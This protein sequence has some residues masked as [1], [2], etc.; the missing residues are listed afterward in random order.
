MTGDL[1]RAVVPKG[2]KTGTHVGRVAVRKTG[3]FNII[4]R[5]ETVQGIGPH[6]VSL[7][8]RGKGYNYSINQLS[9]REE[10]AGMMGGAYSSPRLQPGA[11]RRMR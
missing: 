6:H 2:K 11:S 9:I 3:S 8:Q 7:I 10:V 1:V 5:T 4:T